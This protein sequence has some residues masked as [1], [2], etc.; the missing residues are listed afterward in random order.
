MTFDARAPHAATPPLPAPVGPRW[1]YLHGFASGPGSMKGRAMA[2]HFSRRGVAMEC[3]DLRVP[4]FEQLRLSS[5]VEAVRRAIGGERE[6]AVLMGS[7]LGGLAAARVAGDDPRVAALVLLAPA[8][9]I[10]ERWRER[11]G[12]PGWAAWRDGGFLEVDDDS[13]HTKARVDFGFAEDAARVDEGSGGWPDVRVP[14]L[15][16]HGVQD[17]V[18]DVG[19]SRAWARGKRHVKLVEVEDGHELARSIDRIR[20]EADAFLSPFLDG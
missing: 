2:A 9:R 11:L 17:E 16:V 7:S 14:T 6:R 1:L 3:L 4:S 18:V 15:V 19:L 20:E 8:F 5:I 13:N 10:M 12:E